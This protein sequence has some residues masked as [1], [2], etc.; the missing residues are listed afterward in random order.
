MSLNLIE[1]RLDNHLERIMKAHR[2]A[3]FC[4][5]IKKLPVQSRICEKLLEVMNSCQS[6]IHRKMSLIKE[7]KNTLTELR[8]LHGTSSSS[9]ST[10][11]KTGLMSKEMFDRVK[12]VSTTTER[13]VWALN[14]NKEHLCYI[15]RKFKI[16]ELY[17][18]GHNVDE[19]GDN[20]NAA[21]GGNFHEQ[22][23]SS[24]Y[25]NLN[26]DESICLRRQ[27]ITL[28]E[29]CEL[30]IDICRLLRLAI[31]SLLKDIYAADINDKYELPMMAMVNQ[32]PPPPSSS[33]MLS[34]NSL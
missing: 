3:N 22:K 32:S 10:E 21:G 16:P 25:G 9:S 24:S 30:V 31:T 13:I 1:L 23:N 15:A 29:Q 20:D 14:S 8:A 2:L 7:A 12:Q 4:N 19:V 5:A 26:A 27:L 34:L 28:V 17:C 11:E 18:H 6:L 33:Q